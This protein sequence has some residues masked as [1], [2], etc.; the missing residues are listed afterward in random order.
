M[1]FQGYCDKRK[2]MLNFHESWF[3][4]LEFPRDVTGFYR[5]FKLKAEKMVSLYDMANA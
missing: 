1:N 3:L 2:F 5:I 4:A